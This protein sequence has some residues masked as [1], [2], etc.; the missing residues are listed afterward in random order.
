[1]TVFP[2]RS[3]NPF[4]GQFSDRRSTDLRRMKSYFTYGVTNRWEAAHL[5]TLKAKYPDEYWDNRYGRLEGWL[6]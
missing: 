4:G 3:G 2:G 6:A 1:M 5:A